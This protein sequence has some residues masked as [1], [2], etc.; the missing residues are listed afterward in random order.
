MWWKE[1]HLAI[2]VQADSYIGVCESIN[3]RQSERNCSQNNLSYCSVVSGSGTG[4]KELV[5]CGAE[6]GRKGHEP[7]PE[8]LLSSAIPVCPYAQA[9]QPGNSTDSQWHIKTKILG[10]GWWRGD[11]R[12]VVCDCVEMGKAVRWTDGWT[13]DLMFNKASI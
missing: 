5:G 1:Y 2:K 12:R 4:R 11:W 13:D 6:E 3:F 10:C 8:V 7:S 9:Q